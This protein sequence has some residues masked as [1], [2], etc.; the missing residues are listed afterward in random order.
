MQ[1]TDWLTDWLTDGQEE[2]EVVVTPRVQVNLPFSLD[3]H[4]QVDYSGTL[5]GVRK[6]K[7]QK[8]PRF[9]SGN[10]SLNCCTVSSSF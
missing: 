8:N 7:K 5:E 6:N 4:N 3:A 10:K 9:S 1:L 2:A